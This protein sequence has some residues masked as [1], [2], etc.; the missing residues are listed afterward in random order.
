MKSNI[1]YDIVLRMQFVIVGVN[2]N[3]TTHILARR[4]CDRG[5][6]STTIEGHQPINPCS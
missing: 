1:S 6:I 3:K 2:N 5:R 4:R